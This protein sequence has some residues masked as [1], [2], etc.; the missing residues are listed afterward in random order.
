[1][2]CKI[3]Y[4]TRMLVKFPYLKVLTEKQLKKTILQSLTEKNI[5]T[6]IQFVFSSAHRE[7][8]N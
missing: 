8:L 3:K 6:E 1:M 5:L 2:Q 4:S 7:M